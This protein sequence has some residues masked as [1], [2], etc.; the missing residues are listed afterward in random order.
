MPLGGEPIALGASHTLNDPV[1]PQ[2]AQV[3]GQRA[4]AVGRQLATKQA[5]NQGTQV[6]VAEAVGQVAEAAQRPE[7]R[8]HA[9]I[10]EAQGGDAL[11]GW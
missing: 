11:A 5:G 6:A 10:A 9:R 3:V 4:S 2:P 1:E 7:E 8:V